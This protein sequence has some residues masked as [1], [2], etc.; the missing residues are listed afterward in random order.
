MIPNKLVNIA[1]TV[2]CQPLSNAKVVA[3][4]TSKPTALFMSSAF[5]S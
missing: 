5:K 4:D 3:F 1:A 2:L